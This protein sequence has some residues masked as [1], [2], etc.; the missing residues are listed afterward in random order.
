MASIHDLM[1]RQ[2][3]GRSPNWLARV[4]AVVLTV[5]T[6]LLIETSETQYTRNCRRAVER[7]IE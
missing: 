5:L 2:V 3:G 6:A 7:T 1:G 4:G